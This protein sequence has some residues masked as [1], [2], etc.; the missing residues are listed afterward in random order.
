MNTLAC[1]EDLEEESANVNTLREIYEQERILT[2]M[3]ASTEL[4]ILQSNTQEEDIDKIPTAPS[5]G[6][7]GPTANQLSEHL[8]W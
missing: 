1:K 6:R 5:I 2:L 3:E 8:R 7:K 4:E